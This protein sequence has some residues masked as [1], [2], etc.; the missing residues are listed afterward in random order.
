MLDLKDEEQTLLV[1]SHHLIID[2]ISWRIIL[3]DCITGLKQLVEGSEVSLSLKAHS[4]KEW[5]EALQTIVSEI[6][7]KKLIIDN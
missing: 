4:Y 6:L 1:I 3:D 2:G 5:A 7:V